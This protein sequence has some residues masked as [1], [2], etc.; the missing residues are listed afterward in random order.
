MS[1]KCRYGYMGYENL[2]SLE[3]GVVRSYFEGKKTFK[4]CTDRLFQSDIPLSTDMRRF[5]A[6]ILTERVKPRKMGR[7]STLRRDRC[8]YT[9]IENLLATGISLTPGKDGNS[10]VAEVAIEE[11]LPEDVVLKAYQKIQKNG[12]GNDPLHKASMTFYDNNGNKLHES[13][14]DLLM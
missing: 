9:Q 5:L 13:V 7:P 1:F 2:N 12:R 10:A 8:I 3:M 14:V 4:E 11:N 6:D